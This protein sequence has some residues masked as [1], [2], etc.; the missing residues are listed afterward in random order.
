[1]KNPEDG[2]VY[3]MV[4]G[5][6]IAKSQTETAKIKMKSSKPFSLDGG[7]I[8]H[9]SFTTYRDEFDT[10][11]VGHLPLR[12]IL[13][14]FERARTNLTGG[15]EYMRQLKENDNLLFV[16]TGVED[17][18]LIDEGAR[19]FPGFCVLVETTFRSKRRGIFVES[20]KQP[21]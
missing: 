9:D 7:K 15:P 6:I 10:H 13:N 18:Q 2:T 8:Y 19:C 14:L 1:M 17:F 3:N 4:A 16:V 12:N 5:L 20:G 11:L 21:R